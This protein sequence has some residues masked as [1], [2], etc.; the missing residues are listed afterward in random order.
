MANEIVYSYGT[1][2]TSSNSLEFMQN[3]ES[4]KKQIQTERPLQYLSEHGFK[5]EFIEKSELGY[6]AQIDALIL[7]NKGYRNKTVMPS[8]IF[9]IAIVLSAYTIVTAT[10]YT[11]VK[12]V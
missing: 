2:K 1:Q 3:T 8:L 5:Q 10:T 11:S 6:N 4:C 12:I 7:S 9:S